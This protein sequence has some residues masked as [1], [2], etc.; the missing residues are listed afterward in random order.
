MTTSVEYLTKSSIWTLSLRAC[1]EPNTTG[2]LSAPTY[3]RPLLCR[4]L[5]ALAGHRCA[6]E[7]VRSD[8][9]G[10]QFRSRL[11]LTCVQRCR[12]IGQPDRHGLPSLTVIAAYLNIVSNIWTRSGGGLP[13]HRDRLCALRAR[14]AESRL[15][16]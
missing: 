1:R 3:R 14:W 16:R 7:A 15:R 6:R 2:D 13:G 10:Q 9:P 8:D 12:G 4:C 11:E 5:K